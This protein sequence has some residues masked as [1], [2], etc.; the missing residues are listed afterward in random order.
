MLGINKLLKFTYALMCLAI[1][2]S[3]LA[4]YDNY[5]SSTTDWELKLDHKLLE[6]RGEKYEFN[7]NH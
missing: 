4:G 1:V 5:L 6:K 2:F 7:L 3:L